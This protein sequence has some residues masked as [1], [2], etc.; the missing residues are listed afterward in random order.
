MLVE[1]RWQR[2]SL[3]RYAPDGYRGVSAGTR[4]TSSVNPIAVQ[5]MKEVG[6]DISEQKPK[7]INEDMI[8]SSAKSVNMGCM[9]HAECPMLFINNV[10]DWG[11]DDPKGKPIEQV[12][13]IRDEIEHR[14]KVL[15]K[16]L[17]SSG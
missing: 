11:I 2:L 10:I 1:A 8:R 4:P 9:D 14:V 15:A 7:I 13:T 3:K 12:R 17:K 6:I 16:D 5:A